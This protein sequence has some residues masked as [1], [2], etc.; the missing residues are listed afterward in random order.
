MFTIIEN[1][2]YVIE[3]DKAYEVSLSIDKGTEKIGDGIKLPSSYPIFTAREIYIKF[4]IQPEDAKEEEKVIEEIVEIK[5]DKKK[6][7]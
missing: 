7:K 3:G 2:P 5:K 4:N 6:K 1:K